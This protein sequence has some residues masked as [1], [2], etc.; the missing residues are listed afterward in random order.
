MWSI[1][2]ET[3][4]SVH[5]VSQNYKCCFSNASERHCS[6]CLEN[7]MHIMESRKKKTKREKIMKNKMKAKRGEILSR[8]NIVFYYKR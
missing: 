5:P 7:C 3:T 4:N 6:F 2:P 1:T 8:N